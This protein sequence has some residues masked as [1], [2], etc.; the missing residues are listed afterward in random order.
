MNPQW[1]LGPEMGADFWQ[2]FQ[3]GQGGAQHGRQIQG[4]RRLIQS[5]QGFRIIGIEF[6]EPSKQPLRNL[7]RGQIQAV[8]STKQRE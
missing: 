8:Q 2:L 3:C 4:A 1:K 6:E 7:R 5:P